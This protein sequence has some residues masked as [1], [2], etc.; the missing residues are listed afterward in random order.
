MWPFR[1]IGIFS[2]L[3]L[4]LVFAGRA[5]VAGS[6]VNIPLGSTFYM[7]LERLE[8]KGLVPSSMLST[9][10]LSRLE[11]ARLV[12]EAGVLVRARRKA[13]NDVSSGM[14]IV[15]RLR[16]GLKD[17]IGDGG[18]RSYLKP[19]D[20][21]YSKVLYA[22]KAPVFPNLN[23][24]GDEFGEGGNLRA[25]LTMKANL[26][27]VLSIYMNPEYRLDEESS[28]GR[29]LTGYIK[30]DVLGAELQ[31]G[32][33]SLWWG[34]GKHGAILFTNNA[35]PLDILKITSGH[36]FTLPWVFGRLGLLK[37]TV[38]LARMEKDRDFSNANLLGM[39]LDF[40][41][42]QRLQVGFSRVFMFGGEGR[43]SLDAS[44]WFDVFFVSD[45]AEHASSPINGNQIA[46]MDASYVYVNE[47]GIIP[48]SGIKL[49]TEWGAEDSS[50]KTKTPT[51]R[52][53][54]CGVYI[55]EPF[56]LKN[57]DLRVEWA[58]TA[59]NER[60]G[61]TWYKHGVYTS[62]YTYKGRII[63]HHMG[64]DSRDLFV[65]VRYHTAGGA[66]LGVE[67]EKERSG[68]HTGKKSD[69]R[70]L[71]LDIRYPFAAAHEL[72]L[73]GGVEKV[74]AAGA[75]STGAVVS[76]VYSIFF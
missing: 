76:M 23:N 61:P 51:G 74:E 3:V 9:R 8:V 41:P 2:A 35:E 34:P 49:Y 38:F 24:N 26:L 10:P 16:A 1:R 72:L 70:W 21:L 36:P 28:F 43:R 46:S 22:D 59:R 7:D 42:T 17:E 15:R 68:I 33:D 14:E 37:P 30:L 6:S 66:T 4:F 65:T 54:I 18:R 45:G 71:G 19:V 29:L 69:R 48:F 73:N 57:V 67:A 20:S 53:N 25:G 44:D 11:G 12:Q 55:D 63:G 52:A 50:G 58:N 27:G 5:A 32:R 60:Y 56:W 47:V 13:G 75:G 40:K 64:G 31:A 62:G 39:R